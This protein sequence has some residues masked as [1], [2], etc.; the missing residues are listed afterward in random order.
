MTSARS[1]SPPRRSA[2][3]EFQWIERAEDLESFVKSL[4]PGPL[5]LDT[6]FIGE[7]TYYPTLEIVQ[8]ADTEGRIG[9]IDAPAVGDLGPLAD[10][11][12]DPEREKIFHCPHQDLEI[13]ERALGRLPEPL[14]DTQLAA[15]FV[16]HGLQAAYKNLVQS[17]LHERVGGKHTVSD[18]SRRPLSREQL[19]YCAEDV[20]YLHRL[21][22]KL[23]EGLEREGRAEWLREEQAARIEKIKAAESVPDDARYRDVKE[24]RKL[25]GRD[26][27]VLRELAAWRES[28]AREMNLARRF[29]MGDPGLIALAQFAPR[30][31]EDMTD[32]RRVP[33]GQARK[34][35]RPIL[36]AIGRGLEAPKDTWPRK[37]RH[38]KR[39]APVGVV[40]ALQAIARSTA[41]R[42]RVATTLLASSAELQALAADHARAEELDLAVLRGWR[43]ELAGERLLHFLR[44]ESILAIEGGHR[45]IVRDREDRA[46][47]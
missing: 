7:K 28:A 31:M 37:E 10:P 5:A 25:E 44:G 17:V 6:E 2:P 24:W 11:I 16:G 13:L 35:A 29:V 9:V 20:A 30:R 12:A 39:A 47:G 33:G 19:A 18:W 22:E 14:F 41:D 32:L 40:E 43:R 15:A 23:L 27:A 1:S 4:A 45:L 26:V 34:F 36:A 38:E 42:S 8:V 3:P 21:R 46:G